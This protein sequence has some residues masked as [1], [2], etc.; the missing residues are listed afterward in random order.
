M[1]A[2]LK[3]T[4]HAPRKIRLIA[5]LIKGKPVSQA[6]DILSITPKRAA[7]TMEKLLKSAVANAKNAGA[8]AEALMVKECRVDQGFAFK[9]HMPGARGSAFPIKKY[10]SH[11]NLVLGPAAPKAKKIK[12]AKKEA[13]K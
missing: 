1:K 13:A 5:E 3:N 7:A 2:A 4:R 6:L 12:S 9:R 10:T 8:S 11:V